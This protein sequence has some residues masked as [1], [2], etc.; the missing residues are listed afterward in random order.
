MSEKNFDVQSIAINAN[1]DQVFEFIAEPTNVPKW[2]IGFSAVDGET[3]MMETPNGKMKIGMKMYANSELRT[4]DTVM[5][6]PDGSIGKAFSR[7]TENDNGES[8]VFTFVLMAP[9]VPLEE[10]EG[11]LEEQKKQLKEELQLLKKIIEN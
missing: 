11:T 1:P 4:V 3:A 7:I 6:M 8:A 9:P 10:M 2:A 5:T